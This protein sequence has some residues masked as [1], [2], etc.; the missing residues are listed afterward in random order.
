MEPKAAEPAA[1][2]AAAEQPAA[3]QA[4]AAPA[5]EDP[6]AAGA[7]AEGEDDEEDD[8]NEKCGFCKFMKGGSCR[9]QFIVSEQAG[10]LAG[11]LQLLCTFAA[12]EVT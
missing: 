6:P 9:K 2:A 3:Q 12:G 7:G 5:K 4:E 8:A 11:W 1:P 10:W